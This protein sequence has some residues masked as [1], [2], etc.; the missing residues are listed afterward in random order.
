MNVVGYDLSRARG[1]DLRC[2]LEIVPLRRLV[3][4]ND[5]A[6]FVSETLDVHPRRVLV[7]MM[8]LGVVAVLVSWPWWRCL[9]PGWRARQRAQ[10]DMCRAEMLELTPC[11]VVVS[12]EAR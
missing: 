4:R 1:A 8:F 10:F 2:L 3:T 9:W 5:V 12:L 11:G 7:C 6:C